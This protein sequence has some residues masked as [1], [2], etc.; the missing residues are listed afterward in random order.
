M[1]GKMTWST[2]LAM[3]RAALAAGV[4]LLVQLGCALHWT[5]LMF[6]VS[7]VVGLPLVLVGALLFVHA[8]FRIA[9]SKGAF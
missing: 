3:K 4:G 9:K 1:A 2:T 6:V 7:A 8:V 5:P